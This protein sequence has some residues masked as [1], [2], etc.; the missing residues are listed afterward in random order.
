MTDCQSLF[1]KAVK[2]FF[3]T[4]NFE[5]VKVREMFAKAAEVMERKGLFYRKDSR[6]KPRNFR[7]WKGDY[8]AFFYDSFM[9]HMVFPKKF[10]ASRERHEAIL[11][12]ELQCFEGQTVLDVGVGSGAAA[13]VLP[14][15][16]SYWGVDISPRLLQRGKARFAA[17]SFSRCGFFVASAED[18]PFG[19][20][21]FSL[22]LCALSLNFFPD[23]SRVFQEIRR[24]LQEGG[25]FFCVVPVTDRQV[26]QSVI[27]G[28]LHSEGEL[29]IL[30]EGEGFSFRPLE[31]ENG[32]LLYFEAHPKG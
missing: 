20:H 25:T 19:D 29:K 6:G 21:V 2:K 23:I 24:V 17:R 18:L 5:R 11:R 16:I 10:G 31:H 30:C 27:R 9:K 4:N 7:P 22:C 8:L 28:T 3:E 12:K 32:A 15:N 26:R 13:N 14:S 1:E